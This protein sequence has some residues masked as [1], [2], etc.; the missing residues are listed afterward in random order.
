MST[1]KFYTFFTEMEL[2]FNFDLFYVLSL[3]I[4]YYLKIYIFIC[5]ILSWNTS[6]ICLFPTFILHENIFNIVLSKLIPNKSTL[7]FACF[8]ELYIV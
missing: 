1:I 2:N 8:R 6:V 5:P 3:I 7:Q 4:Y